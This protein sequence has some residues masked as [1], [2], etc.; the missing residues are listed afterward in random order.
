MTEA[1]RR[2]P[3]LTQYVLSVASTL[4]VAV[5]VWIGNT[6]TNTLTEITRI[7]GVMVG[8][9]REL[10]QHDKELS[11]HDDQIRELQAQVKRETERVY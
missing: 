11:R 3:P 4:T 5:L 7:S 10:E 1:E 9:N 2:H 6:A 8:I